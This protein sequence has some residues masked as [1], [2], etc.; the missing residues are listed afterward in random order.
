[1]W[2]RV[3]FRDYLRNHAE[4]ARRYERLKQNLAREFPDDRE[5]YSNGKSEY[6]ES[7][8]AK[9]RAEDSSA[10]AVEDEQ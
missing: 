3:L 6:H 5:G 10:R 9:A 4:E 7:V 8:I 1:M 2:N